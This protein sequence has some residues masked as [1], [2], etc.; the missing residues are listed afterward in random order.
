MSQ[1]E[2]QIAKLRPLASR[3]DVERIFPREKFQEHRFGG[4]IGFTAY[5]G[6]RAEN[7]PR[8]IARN[9]ILEQ[10]AIEAQFPASLNFYGFSIGMTLA[11]AASTISDIGMIESGRGPGFQ[12]FEG[13]TPEGFEIKLR[14]RETLAEIRL[15]QPGHQAITEERQAFRRA[16][17]EE[18]EARRKRKNAWKEISDD[19]DRMLAEWAAHCRPWNDSS[20]SEFTKFASWLQKGSPDERHAGAMICN[21]DYGLAPLLWI[22]RRPD[23]DVATALLIFFGCGPE[24]FLKFG[25]GRERVK[26]ETSS[27]EIFDMMMEIKQRIESEFYVRSEIFFDPSKQVEIVKRHFPTHEEMASILPNN[28]K[29]RYD[30]RRIS[31]ENR[32]DGIRIPPFDIS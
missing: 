20:E 7:E 27:L 1:Y 32:F 4:A 22:S 12:R 6:E 9:D 23:C 10:M 31:R 17:A 16:R 29:T 24:F 15:C 18:E 5:Y 21:W 11:S 30:G 8:G 14:F 19:D 28:L 13:I 26:A 2:E 25:G 3:A